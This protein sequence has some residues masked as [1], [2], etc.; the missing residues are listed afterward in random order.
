[1]FLSQIK[2]LDWQIAA[3]SFALFSLG[4][5]SIYSS[6]L[7]RGNIINLKKQLIFFGIGF[8]LMLLFSFFD[9]LRVLKNYP[10]L[11]FLFYL[12]VVIL[13]IGLF[14][15]A[16]QVRG[17]KSWYKVGDFSIDPAEL[18]KLA[19]LLM[20][21]KY[22][23]RRHIEM[24]S[25]GNILISSL[26]LIIPFLLIFFQPDLG[27]AIILFLLWFGILIISGIQLRHFL[28]LLLII[29]L[30]IGS[31]WIYLLK[32]YQK[33]RV[34]SFLHPQLNPLTI[35]W[36]QTQ[37]KIA[38]GSSNFWGKGFRK[39]SQ[40]QNGFLPEDQTDFI[41]AAITEEFGMFGVLIIFLLYFILIY[42]VIKIA[43]LSRNNFFRFFAAGVAIILVSQFFINI[44]G[45][46]GLLPVIGIS[47]PLVSYGGSN[48]IIT[49]FSLGLVQEIAV[50]G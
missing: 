9:F 28:V 22:F 43:L 34:M 37:S 8:T 21:A 1:M 10:I 18:M 30:L 46:L 49:F 12:F 50:S 11:I 6:S 24:Y 4:L 25:L 23:S 26:Y 20:L 47:L 15:F 42:R 2:K 5:L 13:L 38:I 41:F 14:L 27:S 17:V 19:L 45:N 32:D 29:I 44:G 16:P 48:L 39:G 3:A 33:Q 31:S 36:N 35:G 7:A 40:V